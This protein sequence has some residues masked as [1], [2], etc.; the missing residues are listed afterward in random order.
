[1]LII[2]VG[3]FRGDVLFDLYSFGLIVVWLPSDF[4]RY[5]S[6]LKQLH[7]GPSLNVLLRRGFLVSVQ[8]GCSENSVRKY[9]RQHQSE[10]HEKTQKGT[11]SFIIPKKTARDIGVDSAKD[12]LPS[13]RHAGRIHP[14]HPNGQHELKLEDISLNFSF[15]MPSQWRR[16]LTT[17]TALKVHS[18]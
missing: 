8:E 7:F 1:M 18:Q 3:S 12:K 5:L 6:W 10:K 14:M 17:K 9:T 2:V 11:E 16:T 15:A 13:A 4:F